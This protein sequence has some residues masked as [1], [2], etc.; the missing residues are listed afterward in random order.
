M[1]LLLLV[2][3][4]LLLLL[5]PLLVFFLLLEFNATVSYVPVGK[6]IAVAVLYMIIYFKYLYVVILY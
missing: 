2:L 1:L 6:A 3:L 4:L 5:L